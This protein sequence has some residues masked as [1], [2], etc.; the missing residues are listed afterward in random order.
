MG[1]FQAQLSTDREPHCHRKY[2]QGPGNGRGY[3]HGPPPCATEEEVITV[4]KCDLV[5]EKICT[6]ETIVVGE[7]ITGYE[8]GECKEVEVCAPAPHHG[9][10]YHGYGKR[11]AEP[12]YGCEKVLKK[13]C[14]K[15]PVKTE[16]TK[17]IETCSEVP[18]EVCE[19]VEKVVPKVTCKKVTK[20]NY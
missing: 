16:V 13:V 7:K 14:K 8:E 12:G 2:D 18:K 19:P 20:V 1:T 3:H 4:T 5:P 17:D 6:S 10:G 9:Y 11:S 15:V